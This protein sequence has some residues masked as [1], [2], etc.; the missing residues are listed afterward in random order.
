MSSDLVSLLVEA[1][2]KNERLNITGLLLYKNRSFMQLLEGSE[3]SVREVYAKIC[4]DPRHKWVRT[5]MTGPASERDFPQWFT[6]FENLDELDV[7]AMPGW[8]DFL[9]EGFNVPAFFDDPS[10]AQRLLVDFKHSA[11]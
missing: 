9:S 7:S 2:E 4:V 3:A 1:R 10:F 6:G 8:T 5:L 11:E